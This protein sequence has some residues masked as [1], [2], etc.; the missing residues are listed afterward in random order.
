MSGVNG[1]FCVTWGVKDNSSRIVERRIGWKLDQK[2]KTRGKKERE[3]GGRRNK[4]GRKKVTE[5]GRITPHPNTVVFP[6]KRIPLYSK[7][8][9]GVRGV[10]NTIHES[11]PGAREKIH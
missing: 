4:E 2:R 6:G 7:S 5:T 10:G 8:R 3:T 9:E 11:D 1:N